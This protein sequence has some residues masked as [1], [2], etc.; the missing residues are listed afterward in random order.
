M[1]ATDDASDV[2]TQIC[3][4]FHFD[5][6]SIWLG[7]F[8]LTTPNYVSR[9]DFEAETA[10]PR[11]LDL[12]DRHNVS[13]TWFVSGLD[14]ETYPDAVKKI[15]DAGHEIAHHGYSHENVTSLNEAA[16]REALER[17]FEALDKVLGVKPSG[18]RSPSYDL[19]SNSTRVLESYGFV[20]DSSLMGRD[21]EMYRARTG[22]Q[23]SRAK[24][25]LGQEID[26]VEV[27]VSW[28]L[29]D[30]AFMEFVMTPGLI[31]PGSIDTKAL[32]E[33]WR[34]DLDYC[35]G[36]VRDGIFTPTFHAQTI[37]RGSKINL[38]EQLVRRGHEHGAPF[39]TVSDAVANWKN[40]PQTATHG[41][42]PRD[43]KEL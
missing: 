12:L 28:T 34:A 9:A 7:T 6:L 21:F 43:A 15:R 31:L 14:A 17:G 38:L 32:G 35:V 23:M 36:N 42:A 20:W 3:L 40:R 37:G 13:A 16:E 27:P 10:T 25:L 11:I 1:S 39:H 24:I 5:A 29:N 4:T 41:R 26:L 33:R 2:P 19:S 22:D 8:G 30:F 18:Y